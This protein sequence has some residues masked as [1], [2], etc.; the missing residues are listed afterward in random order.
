MKR[1]HV[2]YSIQSGNLGRRREKCGNTAHRRK[3]VEVGCEYSPGEKGQGEQL[4]PEKDRKA[5]PPACEDDG[6]ETAQAK[7]ENAPAGMVLYC[8]PHNQ[9]KDSLGRQGVYVVSGSVVLLG[10][11]KNRSYA[12]TSN[13]VGN[14][15]C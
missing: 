11:S 6:G 4:G 8:L 2:G 13:E 12:D 14:G 10:K 7:Q 9:Q 1:I 5:A 3:C 15:T